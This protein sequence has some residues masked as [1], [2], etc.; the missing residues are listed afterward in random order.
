M[1]E[2]CEI[3]GNEVN[4]RVVDGRVNNQEYLAYHE[5]Q[6]LFP[7]HRKFWHEY[8]FNPFEQYESQQL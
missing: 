5:R 3:C 8:R 1:R 2:R 7:Q 6:A 4:F